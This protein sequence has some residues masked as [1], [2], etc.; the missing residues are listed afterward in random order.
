MSFWP[1]G[2]EA[3]NASPVPEVT[4]SNETLEARE[5]LAAA[6]RTFAA[7][8]SRR[9]EVEARAKAIELMNSKNHFKDLIRQALGAG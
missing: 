4:P 9:P 8:R 3:E 5:A 6:E 7:A 1:W 2:N